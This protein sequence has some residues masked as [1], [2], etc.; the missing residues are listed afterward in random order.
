LNLP[1]LRP[2]GLRL[3]AKSADPI[4]LLGSIG[5]SDSPTAT[6][7]PQLTRRRAVLIENLIFI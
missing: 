4:C 3:P 2:H 5:G 7:N 6:V 1:G